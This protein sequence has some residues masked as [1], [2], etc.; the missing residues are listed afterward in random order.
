MALKH[1]ITGAGFHWSYDAAMVN[2][3]MIDNDIPR[4]TKSRS[5]HSIWFDMLSDHGFVGLGLFIAILVSFA[6]DA[7]WLIRHSRG[8]PDLQ[9]ANSL[10]RL[11][12]VS[13]VGYLVGGTFVSLALYDGFFALV[14]ITASARQVVAAELA[15][16]AAPAAKGKFAALPPIAPLRPQPT[17]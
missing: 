10:G 7:Q 14:I 4:L 2:R 11:L 13:L 6:L 8:D 9:L 5:T 15:R 3:E 1:P 12:Q 17:G 16:R